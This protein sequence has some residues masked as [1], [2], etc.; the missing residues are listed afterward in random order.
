MIWQVIVAIIC[1]F[2]GA[3][4]FSQII[5]VIKYSE[6]FSGAQIARIVILWL[7]ILAVVAVIPILI[8]NKLWIGVCIGYGISFLASTHVTPD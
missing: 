6:M 3:F 8:A 5:G 2:V 7:V 4:G 1:W